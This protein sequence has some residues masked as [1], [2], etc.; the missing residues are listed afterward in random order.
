MLR[1]DYGTGLHEAEGDLATEALVLIICGI[2]GHWK[3]PVA[4]LLQN[5]N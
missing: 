1:A 2:T 4:Y 5:K 3:H